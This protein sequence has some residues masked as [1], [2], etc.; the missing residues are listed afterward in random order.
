M[1][2]RILLGGVLGGL[3]LFIWGA[4]SHMVFQL[5]VVGIQSLPTEEATLPALRGAVKQPG[6]Y[7]FPGMDMAAIRAMPKEQA[8]AATKQWTEK[9]KAGPRGVLVIHPE[10][11]SAE[12]MTAGTLGRQLGVDVI[13]GLLV[14]FLMSQLSTTTRYS[15]RVGFSTAIGFLT[16]WIICVPYWN[17]YG[18]PGNFTMAQVADRTIGFALLGL[19]MAAIVNPSKKAQPATATA[20][21]APSS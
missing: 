9:W 7:F 11:T 4:L 6:F 10:P 12:P 15:C 3:V 21:A 18:F 17:W 20:A 16:G 5:G 13:A 14:A 8:D 2:K 19:A 1:T